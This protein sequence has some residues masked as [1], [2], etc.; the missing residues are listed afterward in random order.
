MPV[1]ALPQAD[2]GRARRAMESVIVV[3]YRATEVSV[4]VDAAT[5]RMASLHPTDAPGSEEA[6]KPSSAAIVS[7]GTGG[8]HLTYRTLAHAPVT[9]AR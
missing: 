1:G 9:P 8:S 3:G 7:H 2:R 6:I 4:G 5:A